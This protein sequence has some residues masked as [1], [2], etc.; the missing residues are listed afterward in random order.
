MKKTKTLDEILGNSNP[1]GCNQ[2]TGPGCGGVVSKP[3]NPTPHKLVVEDAVRAKKDGLSA[4]VGETLVLA[5]LM[6][7]RDGSP[8]TYKVGDYVK[9]PSSGKTYLV[10]AIGKKVVK[11]EG[12]TYRRY[13]QRFRVKQPSA[14]EM[15]EVSQHEASA[16]EARRKVLTDAFLS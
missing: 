3:E 10:T 15:A 8:A 5:D 11:M 2:H 4:K 14:E 1:E 16:E 9:S 6:T 12:D 7:R 13:Y